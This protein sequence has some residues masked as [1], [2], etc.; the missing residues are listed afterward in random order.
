MFAHMYAWIYKYFSAIIH[1]MYDAQCWGINIHFLQTC[2]MNFSVGLFLGGKHQQTFSKSAT[3]KTYGG[4]VAR[5]PLIFHQAAPEWELKWQLGAQ[6]KKL[7]QQYTFQYI[8]KEKNIFKEIF[9]HFGVV[10]DSTFNAICCNYFDRTG[11]EHLHS[12]KC[13]A[14][15]L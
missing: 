10:L 6:G 9:Q 11:F 8:Y 12:P 3:W 14:W 13:E 7:I 4:E 15:P 1:S 5:S 2:D